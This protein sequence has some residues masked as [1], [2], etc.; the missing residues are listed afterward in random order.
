M[1]FNG[2]FGFHSTTLANTGLVFKGSWDANANI[3]FL[4]SGIGVNGEYYI[5]SV[6]GTTN[7]D[8]TNVWAVG[9]WAIFESATN[10]WQK[11][12]N[13][14]ISAYSFIQ[15]E[16]V[17]LPQENILDFQGAGVTASAGIGKTIVTIPGN[18][19]PT[20]YGLFAQTALSTPITF[21]TGE[22][23]L[24]GVG[25][26][27]LIVPANAFS[28]GDSFLCKLCGPISCANNQNIRF[29]VKSNGVILIDTGAIQMPQLTNKVYD[30][31]IDFTITKIGGLGVAELF[32]NSLYSYNKDSNNQIEGF[33]IAI[34]DSTTFDT[35]IINTLDVTAEWLS[36]NAANT[37]RSQN[38]VL[39]KVY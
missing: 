39:K 25:V 20:T 11:I 21:A 15:E 3:P 19:Q 9:D 26:G 10:M 35:T 4:Q 33:N 18:I 31:A 27:T 38:F 23:T 22:Q 2:A 24:F 17:N 7:L 12:A 1:G 6:A 36:N 37:I 34:I 14:V 5:V 16:G 30:L 8:G 13:S 28:V 32:A 29:K